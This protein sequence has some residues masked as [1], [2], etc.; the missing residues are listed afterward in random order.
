MRVLLI[1]TSEK[2]GGAAVAATRLM[3][4]LKNNGV[5]AKLLVRDKQT[6]NISVVRLESNYVR[7]LWNFVWER[8]I[9]WKANHFKRTNLFAVDIANTGTDITALAEFKEA[10]IVH[11]HWMNQGM[12]SLKNI[13]KIV[14]SGKPVVWTMH[15][16][17]SCTGICH[18]ACECTRYREECHHCPYLYGGGGEKDLSYRIFQKKKKLYQ[19]A[20]MIFV[21]CSRW[22]EKSAKESALFPSQTVVSIPNPINVNLFKPR[23]KK[24]ARVK[25]N[26]PA[27]KKLILFAS[28]K[29]TDKRKGIDYLIESCRILAEKY[30]ELKDTM[31]IVILGH[32]S[33]QSEQLPLPFNVHPLPFTGKEDELVN[34]YN[35]VDLYVTPSLQ[36]NL[37][38]T[39]MEAMACGVPCVGFDT[40]GISE[41]IDHLHNGYVARY[42]SAEDFAEGI[43][44]IATDPEYDILSQQARRKVIANYSE[45]Y[46]AKKY[47]EI[48]NRIIGDYV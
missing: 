48:Y 45:G 42:K 24:E 29:I 40:G 46:I 34:V 8:I 6:D 16:M 5:K 41:M 7:N 47:I 14:V 1:N 27:E 43:Y 20:S 37:P 23:N 18:H 32:K 11:L 44:R 33:E 10:D 19:K 9:I 12:L 21:T 4:A 39:I 26:L 3:E 35:A 28:V 2:I 17:W 22:L 31:E 38:N 30:P 36:E 15:D 25:C 13:Q